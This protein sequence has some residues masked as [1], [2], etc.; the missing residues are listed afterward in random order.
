MPVEVISE[1]WV[2]SAWEGYYRR[3]DITLS[4]ITYA[5]TVKIKGEA[6]DL[7]GNTDSDQKTYWLS[8]ACP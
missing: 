3:A 5:Q 4:G 2:G 6:A 8:I 1:G 7:G